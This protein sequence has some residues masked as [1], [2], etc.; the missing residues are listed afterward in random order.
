MKDLKKLN[1]AIGLMNKAE[2]KLRKGKGF[3]KKIEEKVRK[4]E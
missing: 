4:V 2:E 1:K 3:L